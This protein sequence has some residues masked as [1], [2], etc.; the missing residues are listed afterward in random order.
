MN[1]IFS[2]VIIGGLALSSWSCKRVNNDGAGLC[3]SDQCGEY[4]EV[5][6]D[7]FLEVNDMD[8]AYYNDHI[9]PIETFIESSESG[10]KFKIRFTVKIDWLEMES[11]DEFMIRIDENEDKFPQ[12]NL[13]KATYL[14]DDQVAVVL[15]NFAFASNVTRM[16]PVE[17]LAQSSQ[18][19]ALSQ[20]R[21]LAAEKDLEFRRFEFKDARLVFEPNGHP[22]MYG[23]AQKGDNDC[24]CGEIDLVTGE[25][26]AYECECVIN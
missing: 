25:G 12:L 9:F 5:W 18:K 4:L 2:W 1:R 21:N 24:N 17:T 8:E 3:L 23:V 10:E 13:P 15:D 22:Y 11:R 26:E 16:K 7:Y 14:N 19:K 20:L 6:K